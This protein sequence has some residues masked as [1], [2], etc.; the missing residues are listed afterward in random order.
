MSTEPSKAITSPG[1][2]PAVPLEQ[3]AARAAAHFLAHF[4]EHPLWMS[5]APGRINVIGEH[6]DY[7]DGL[8]LPMAID[9]HVV[10]A[11]APSPKRGVRL[12]SALAREEVMVP[13]DEAL[14]PGRPSW[15]NYVRG[16]LQGFSLRGVSIPGMTVLIESDVP[17]GGGLSSSA[18][19]EVATAT[20]V[21][22]VSGVR[23][24]PAQKA[25]LCQEAEHRFA[26][27]P[28]G[29]MDQFASVFGLEDHLLLLDCQT[30]AVTPVALKDR[31]VTFLVINTNVRHELGSSA[32]PL[33]RAQCEDA[34]RRMGLPSLRDATL[35]RWE[36]E[37]GGWPDEV[38]RR[39]R[40]VISEISRTR[41]AAALL[42]RGDWQNAGELMYAGHASLRD[43]FEVSCPELD[44]VVE[45]ARECG[46]DEGVFGCRMTG[47]GFGGCCV[48][49]VE[50]SRAERLA[51]RIGCAYAART[52]LEPTMFLSRPS[53]GAKVLDLPELPT[54]S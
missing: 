42:A 53:G 25:L 19:L 4:G 15:A 49:L 31:S 7:C 45:L 3:K 1:L 39:A 36:A 46:V 11:A 6:V 17:M 5:A 16:V 54:E 37:S 2:V 26:G 35:A 34:A 12:F 48:A 14:A 29:I 51:A 47:G 27:V 9:R 28:C 50:S 38:R 18:A 44:V 30:Q 8:V 24:A 41:E 43:D 23:L 52:A 21:E 13:L 20:L 40:H 33:R 22:L 10:M 32:Y